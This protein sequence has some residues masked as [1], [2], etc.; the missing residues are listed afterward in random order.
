MFHSQTLGVSRKKKKKKAQDLL[1]QI[2]FLIKHLISP[3]AH[4]FQVSGLGK[5]LCAT[6]PSYSSEAFIRYT[7]TKFQR[8]GSRYFQS[9]TT[10]YITCSVRAH[11]LTMFSQFHLE[12]KK[13][14]VGSQKLTSDSTDVMSDKHAELHAV[15]QSQGIT[16]KEGMQFNT[17]IKACMSGCTFLLPLVIFQ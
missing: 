13:T 10:D 7:Y 1:L 5:C 9:M 12:I 2:L 17:V 16:V 15:L 8:F 11:F 3:Q 14:L 6:G 4:A